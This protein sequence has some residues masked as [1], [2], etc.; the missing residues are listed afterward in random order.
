[1]ASRYWVGGTGTWDTTST[2]H[3]A[4]TTGGAS[5]ASVPTAADD[6]FFDYNSL[7][8]AAH[9][10]TLQAGATLNCK[11]LTIYAGGGVSGTVITTTGT[12][13][14]CA[15]GINLQS[16]AISYSVILGTSTIQCTGWDVASSGNVTLSAAA[17]SITLN[18][19]AAAPF[20][21]GSRTY[22]TVEIGNPT[23]ASTTTISG[24]NTF[25][26]LRSTKTVAHTIQFPPTGTTTI[27]SWGISGRPGAAVTIQSTVNGQ[28]ATL[29]YSSSGVVSAD[30]LRAQYIAATP[31]N[32][33][34]VGA[35]SVN[36]GNTSGLIFSAAPSAISPL[37]FGCNF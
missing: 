18:A 34:Y 22:G 30:Y 29:A 13:L 33:W 24:A 14:V 27:G 2:A 6:V 15:G 8:N 19:G 20:F 11:S 1:M 28:T 32:T 5:G 4:S 16:S 31:S 35:N 3:W 12:N 9:T 36:L 37:F 7:S 23:V 17:T 26:V 25:A 21:G 10:I